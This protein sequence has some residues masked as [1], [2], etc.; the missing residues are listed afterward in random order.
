MFEIG[1]KLL[2]FLTLY[3]FGSKYCFNPLSFWFSE[4]FYS[5][6]KPNRRVSVRLFEPARSVLFEFYVKSVLSVTICSSY[7]ELL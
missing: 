3:A 2:I 5:Y 4:V 1:A 6:F 7:C